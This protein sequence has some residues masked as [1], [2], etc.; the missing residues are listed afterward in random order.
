MKKILACLL[1][2]CMLVALVSCGKEKAPFEDVKKTA[3]ERETDVSQKETLPEEK[4][5]ENGDENSE[6]ATPAAKAYEDL[7]GDFKEL[8]ELSIEGTIPPNWYTALTGD[9]F[10][11]TLKK[12]VAEYSEEDFIAQFSG[13]L[14]EFF[15]SEEKKSPERC[16]CIEFDLNKDGV[17]EL[18]WVREDH[19]ILAIFT[20]LE[21]KAVLLDAFWS[22]YE[23]FV[24]DK[25]ELY[26]WGS[27]GEQDHRCSIFRLNSQGKLEIVKSFSSGTDF[28]G[29]PTKVNYFETID[30]QRQSITSSRFEELSKE[31][32]KEQSKTWM[33]MPVQSLG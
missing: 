28:F 20:Y 2:F 8:I 30:S 3:E 32:P 18:F 12:T 10:S 27:S 4:T 15:S 6:K 14:S 33:A 13:A 22:R 26:G 19:S 17:S 7:Q 24:S 5:P 23:G 1:A 31:Y 11:D 9:G 16:G 29:D 21:N 25:G